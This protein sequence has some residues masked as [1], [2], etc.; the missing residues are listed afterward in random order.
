MAQ[1]TTP[2]Q[3]GTK[4][5][6]KRGSDAMQA[7]K[8]EQAK[9]EA[10]R[11]AGQNRGPLRFYVGKDARGGYSEHELIF[12]D[13]DLTQ[14]PFAYEHTIAG[15]GNDWS[16]ARSFVCVDEY[17]DCALCRAAEQGLGEEFTPARY[18]MYATVL[19]MTPYTVRKGQRAGEVIEYSRKLMVIPH[20]QAGQFLKM[21]ELCKSQNG[22]TRGMTV[23][24]TKT[25]QTDARCGI[26]QM[27]DNGMLFDFT[28]E[29][30]LDE[31]AN[32][33]VRR[34]NKVVKAEGEDIEPLEYDKLLAPLD[35]KAIRALFNIPAPPGS[36]E[37]EQAATGTGRRARRRR[38]VGEGEAEDQGAGEAADEA[39]SPPPATTAATGRTRRR[40]AP[41]EPVPPQTE[42]P[43]PAASPRRRRH[44]TGR[45]DEIPF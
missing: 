30:E 44:G 14:A 45:D 9:A 25:Q 4:T 23:V 28:P 11:A 1:A 20:Q 43:Q 39:E 24:V 35:Q 2:R 40:A 5:F 3:R 32:E 6:L 33:E 19:D 8:Q 7:L 17:D 41:A 34:D 37:E 26:P 42:S 12:L 10:N 16:K 18:G 13:D 15:P 31:Y 38:M 21:A 22:T 36:E 27:L 29:D